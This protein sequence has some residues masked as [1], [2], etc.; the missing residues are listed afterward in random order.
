[1]NAVFLIERV[2]AAG[3]AWDDDPGEGGVWV[4]LIF[5]AVDLGVP[6][7]G[8]KIELNPKC[9]PQ[10]DNSM[11][12]TIS[13]VTKVRRFIFSFLPEQVPFTRMDFTPV[14]LKEYVKW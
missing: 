9:R 4:A 3:V 6:L 5:L 1:M 12:D 2:L 8:F 14:T 13:I 7:D 10:D 11:A